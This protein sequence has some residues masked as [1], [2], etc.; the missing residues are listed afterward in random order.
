MN[1][2]RKAWVAVAGM[3]AQ[4]A[5]ILDQILDADVVPESWR[6]WVVLAVAVAT[7]AGV[8]QVPNAP[9]RHEDAGRARPSVLAAWSAVL[10]LVLAGG[11]FAGD[12][13]AH[14]RP[15]PHLGVASAVQCRGELTVTYGFEELAGRTWTPVPD[16]TGARVEVRHVGAAA[17]EG[18]RWDA[19]PPVRRVEGQVTVDVA[20][21]PTWDLVRVV[22]PVPGIGEVVSSGRYPTAGCAE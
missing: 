18:G 4:L 21:E 12:A 14:R 10:A 5:V 19:L 13:Q 20:G 1:R 17:G 6:P 15:V 11:L 22:A 7:A 8:R 16:S 9:G 3:L 2:Y